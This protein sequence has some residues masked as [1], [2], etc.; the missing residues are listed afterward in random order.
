MK[1]KKNKIIIL[2]ALKYYLFKFKWDYFSKNIDFV[3]FFFLIPMLRF[4]EK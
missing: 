3:F 2:K 1:I 4:F